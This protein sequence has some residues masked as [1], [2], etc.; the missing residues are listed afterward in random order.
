M[1]VK[2]TMTCP[3]CSASESFLVEPVALIQA[4][5]VAGNG[6]I[7]N[8]AFDVEEVDYPQRLK[9]RTTCYTCGY[10]GVLGEFILER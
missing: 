1:A 4:V 3:K 8:T 6:D 10:E 5:E 2:E 7:I 9:T